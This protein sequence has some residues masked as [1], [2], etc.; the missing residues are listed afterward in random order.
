MKNWLSTLQPREIIILVLAIVVLG[1]LGLHALV[2]E[3]QWQNQERL[4]NAL[5]REQATLQWLREALPRLKAQKGGSTKP[6][7]ATTTQSL[8]SEIDTLNKRF[9]VNTQVQRLRP[10]GQNRLRLWFEDVPYSNLMRW[11]QAVDAKGIAFN[12]VRFSAR[13]RGLVNANF[14]LQQEA[15][16]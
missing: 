13:D 10:Q 15:G 9:G 3:P 12:E 2:L 5:A 14:D 6:G 4:H 1:G 11:L 8:V 16:R 7:V